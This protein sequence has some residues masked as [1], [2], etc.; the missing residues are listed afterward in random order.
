MTIHYDFRREASYKMFELASTLPPSSERAQA[1]RIG[2]IILNMELH[3]TI[4]DNILNDHKSLDHAKRWCYL[5][6][7]TNLATENRTHPDYFGVFKFIDGS[8][9]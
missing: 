5:L 8:E 6:V 4:A 1:Y 9:L 7:E 2:Y 3:Q